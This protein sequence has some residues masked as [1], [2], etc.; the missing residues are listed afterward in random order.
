MKKIREAQEQKEAND[1]Y[2]AKIEALRQKKLNILR[3]KGVPEKYLVDIM[4][5]R[6]ELK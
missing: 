1:A 2:L 3:A 4:A 5:D 6:F